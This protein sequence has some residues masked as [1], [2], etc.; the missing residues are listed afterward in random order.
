MSDKPIPKM[1]RFAP[2]WRRLA[3]S[4]FDNH[5]F[6]RRI[7]TADGSC[8]VYVTAGAQLSVL[9]PRGVPIDPVHRR[10]IAQWVED[11]SIIWDI[12]GNMGLFAFPSVL[13]ASKGHVYMFEPDVELAFN[14]IRSLRRPRNKALPVTV[15]PVALSDQD[16]VSE[17]LISG[18]GRSMNKLAGE[19]RWHDDL[20]IAS[21]ARTVPVFRIDTIAQSLRPPSILKI[22]VEG[23]EVKVLEGG[24]RTI[25]QCRPV[26]LI[27]V[28]DEHSG[29]I[30]DYFSKL[31]YVFT[32]GQADHPVPIQ[33]PVWDTVAIPRER[34][35]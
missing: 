11:D 25:A 14:L 7:T 22:D 6:R 12:G 31:D 29:V 8:D 27:E 21:G 3:Y 19:S 24:R 32:D 20:F 10:F 30:R 17:F 18:H 23:A 35:R 9:D 13:K 2:A 15:L 5:F 28:P 4:Y 26:V 1:G 33:S 16:N 34:F